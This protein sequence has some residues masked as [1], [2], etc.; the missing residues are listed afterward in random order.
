LSVL[1]ELTV[2]T[3]LCLV[4]LEATVPMALTVLMA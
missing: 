2:L 1:M 3:L 4:L